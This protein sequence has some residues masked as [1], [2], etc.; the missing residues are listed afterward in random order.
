[1]LTLTQLDR[2]GGTRG[3][4]SQQC[5]ELSIGVFSFDKFGLTFQ[6]VAQRKLHPHIR[7]SGLA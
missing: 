5:K 4:L 2:N 7:G 3:R 6:G 1:L